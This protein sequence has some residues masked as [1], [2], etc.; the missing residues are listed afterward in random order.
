MLTTSDRVETYR[1]LLSLADTPV[2]LTD[3]DR[4][5]L[6]MLAVGIFGRRHGFG[7][8]EEA[9]RAMWDNPAARDEL[10]G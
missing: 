1:R 10:D 8:L 9:L 6:S 2:D 5:L 3:R 7:N 4:R